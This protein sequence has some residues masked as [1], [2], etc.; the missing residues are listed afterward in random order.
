MSTG[1][2]FLTYFVVNGIG[3]CFIYVWLLFCYEKGFGFVLAVDG[4]N[5]SVSL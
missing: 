1:N 2:K 5:V 3:G 4:G